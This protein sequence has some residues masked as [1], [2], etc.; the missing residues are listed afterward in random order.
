MLIPW[1]NK[2]Y[3]IFM[4][5]NEQKYHKNRMNNFK[6]KEDIEQEIKNHN[7]RMQGYL[8]KLKSFNISN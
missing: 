5:E 6:E 4:M 1:N 7:I 3:I 2:S 8:E